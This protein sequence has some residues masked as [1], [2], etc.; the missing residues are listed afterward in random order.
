MDGFFEKY[1]GV[2]VTI[3]AG[4]ASVFFVLFVFQGSSYNS[5]MS[6]TINVGLAQESTGENSRV[7][8]DVPTVEMHVVNGILDYDQ[9]FN[10]KDYVTVTI[11]GTT[12]DEYKEYVSII[13]TVD[14]GKPQIEQNVTYL[15]KWNG[16][17]KKAKAT[18]YVRANP[19]A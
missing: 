11:D 7:D 17:T 6:D 15:L 9:P 12:L 1:L 10:Y 4:I 2:I 3:L 13:G 18:F 5:A 8:Y 19:A 16:I 14:T